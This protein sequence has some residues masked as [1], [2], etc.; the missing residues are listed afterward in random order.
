MTELPREFHSLLGTMTDAAVAERAGVPTRVAYR[1]R[2]ALGID[3]HGGVRRP[4]WQPPE[5]F[6]E[7]VAG[8]PSLNAAAKLLGASAG[9]VTVN[10][11]MRQIPKPPQW[12]DPPPKT[13]RRPNPSWLDGIRDRLGVAS[14]AEL[15]AEVGRSRERIRQVRQKLGIPLRGRD[16][17]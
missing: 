14:D 17:S 8:A 5:D 6:A 12:I 15:A 2:R 11:R 3:A 1:A 7:V 4:H 16:A 9:T 10:L 13:P